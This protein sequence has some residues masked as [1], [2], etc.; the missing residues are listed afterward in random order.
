MSRPT[1]NGILIETELETTSSP[2]DIASG[3]RSGFASATILRK[4]EAVLPVSAND[5][6][7]TRERTEGFGAGGEVGNG[8]GVCGLFEGESD[9]DGVAGLFV[10]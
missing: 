1:V 5:A 7:R 2:I 9:S 3:L 8:G 4:E 10:D 6:G